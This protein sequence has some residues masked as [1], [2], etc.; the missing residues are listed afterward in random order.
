MQASSSEA[1]SLA[2][3]TDA[4]RRKPS[5][6]PSIV[7]LRIGFVGAFSSSRRP[8]TAALRR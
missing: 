5:Q 8:P 2:G 1:K 3:R 4:A 6:W 7:A